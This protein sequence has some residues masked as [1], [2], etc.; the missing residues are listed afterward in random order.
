MQIE[1]V[2]VSSI[3]MDCSKIHRI[4]LEQALRNAESRV[5]RL[6]KDVVKYQQE[7]DTAIQELEA[8]KNR[9]MFA[10]HIRSRSY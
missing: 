3:E 2:Q 9:A 4:V 8:A 10:K 5:K 7:L 6:F 1:R